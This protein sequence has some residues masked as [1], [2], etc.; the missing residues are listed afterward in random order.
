MEHIEGLS[1]LELTGTGGSSAVY[2]ATN[3][4]DEIVA[5]KV[6]SGVWDESGV[7]RFNREVEAMQLLDGVRGVVPVLRTGVVDDASPF[8]VMPYYEKGSLNDHLK[9]HGPIPWEQATT[10]ITQLAETLT[11]THNHNIYHRDLK[12]ANILQDNNDQYWLTDFGIT[13]IADGRS[14]STTAAY[15]PGYCP[16]ET[17]TQGRKNT[18]GATV[19]TYGLTATLWALIA[20][21]TPFTNPQEPDLDPIVL[22]NNVATKPIGPPNNQTPNWLNRII[23]KGT[24]KNPEHRYQNIPTLLHDLQNQHTPE[25]TTQ[26]RTT[27]P[28]IHRPHPNNNTP[29]TN[30]TQTTK[31]TKRKPLIAAAITATLLLVTAATI[32]A[33]NQNREPTQT[34]DNT[35][36]S[37]TQTEI[38]PSGPDASQ[39]IDTQSSAPNVAAIQEVL[40]ANVTASIEDNTVI[41]TGTVESDEERTAA[42]ETATSFEGVNDVVDNITVMP[43]TTTIAPT[44][45]TPTTPMPTPPPVTQPGP[46]TIVL[47]P[48]NSQAPGVP[49]VTMTGFP[50]GASIMY[51]CSMG[52]SSGLFAASSLLDGPVSID[53]NGKASFSLTG[54]QTTPNPAQPIDITVETDSFSPA[55]TSNTLFL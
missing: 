22:L 45:T 16:P 49:I 31:T 15:T 28:T 38:D 32:I 3:Q 55:V 27:E 10:I 9:N 24:A 53:A 4:N 39:A 41:L 34:A 12:P 1:G 51:I 43:A 6:L 40:P 18:N 25:P 2:K 37:T 21:H 30:T 36:P 46:P 17:L 5:V 7:R 33:L 26:K 42:V 13:E 14:L 35:Q 20:G 47:A 48:G 23:E 19:D 44:P 11:Q 54:C 52:L 8:L 50:P 29:K